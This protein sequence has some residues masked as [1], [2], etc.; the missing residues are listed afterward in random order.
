[1]MMLTRFIFCPPENAGN[2]LT[3][4][5]YPL[6]VISF[7]NFAYFDEDHAATNGE[8]VREDMPHFSFVW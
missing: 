8:E 7:Y 6:K 2:Y 1:M 3:V 5:Y 4:D